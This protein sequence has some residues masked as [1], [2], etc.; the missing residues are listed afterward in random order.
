[1]SSSNRDDENAPPPKEGPRPKKIAAKA[2]KVVIPPIKELREVLLEH[3]L[4]T[5]GTKKQLFH[6]LQ[7]HGDCM[8]GVLCAY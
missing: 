7:N 4:S 2:A 1:M 6:R 3:G 8:N 5:L